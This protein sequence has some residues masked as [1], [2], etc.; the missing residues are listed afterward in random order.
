LHEGGYRILYWLPEALLKVVLMP[1]R[2]RG[3]GRGSPAI[4][5]WAGR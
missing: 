3:R 1:A 5:D 2:R 4:R